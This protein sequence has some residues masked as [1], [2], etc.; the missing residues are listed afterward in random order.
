MEET[1][2]KFSDKN[3]PLFFTDY[4]N[5]FGTLHTFAY[6]FKEKIL[7]TNIAQGN[8]NLI[9]NFEEWVKGNNIK[10]SKLTGHIEALV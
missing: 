4:D 10:E 9:I 5:L 2:R 3:S 1:F 6:S 8:N 7:I